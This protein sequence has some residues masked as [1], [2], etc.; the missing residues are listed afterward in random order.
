MPAMML[1]CIAASVDSEA[2]PP[3]PKAA[4]RSP[5]RIAARH[6]VAACARRRAMNS[7]IIGM[8]DFLAS[9]MAF[10]VFAPTAGSAAYQ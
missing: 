8:A 4:P 10:S 1:F 3:R 5:C 9:S 7:R 6:A 2:G